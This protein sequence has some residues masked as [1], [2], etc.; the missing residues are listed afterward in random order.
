MFPEQ[1]SV[2]LQHWPL[3]IWLNT[4]QLLPKQVPTTQLEPAATGFWSHVPLLQKVSVQRLRSPGQ[5]GSEA[6]SRHCPARQ[7][8]PCPQEAP[9]SFSV[10]AGLV[11]VQL[12][13]EQSVES[14]S[15]GGSAGSATG[16]LLP[17]PS[18]NSFV[19]LPGAPSSTVVLPGFGRGA[20]SPPA[21]WLSSKHGPDGGAQ[22]AASCDAVS[23]PQAPFV[24][25]G[26]L[27]VVPPL[28]SASI[29]HALLPPVPVALDVTVVDVVVVMLVDAPP[30]DVTL[31][32]AA[33]PLPS[34]GRPSSG[35]LHPCTAAS[36]VATIA[37]I[38][39]EVRMAAA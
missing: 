20:H 4:Q 37:G 21:H 25:F 26:V 29:E 17:V 24:H 1:C 28:H 14:G 39:R 6:H 9:S 15:A 30:A 18:Q 11:P 12:G 36:A 22:T 27:H 31:V 5:S 38:T 3:Q 16:V 8:H 19:Q 2:K 32:A 10:L 23:N 13:T 33:P 35:K 34:G 7:C